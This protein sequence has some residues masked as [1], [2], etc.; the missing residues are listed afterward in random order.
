MLPDP[1]NDPV[2]LVHNKINELEKLL[3]E[4]LKFR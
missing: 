2:N 1:S 4:L 3:G